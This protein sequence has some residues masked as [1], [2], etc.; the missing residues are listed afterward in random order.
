MDKFLAS[1]GIV[2]I[3]SF[4]LFGLAQLFV[5]TM[6]IDYHFGSFWAVVSFILAIVFRFTLPVTI[7]SYFGALNVLGW[8]WYFALA[9]AAPGLLFILPATVGVL[10]SSLAKSR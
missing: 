2:G 5:G 7:G 3:I 6:G 10:L 8:D 4:L 1:L 9:F